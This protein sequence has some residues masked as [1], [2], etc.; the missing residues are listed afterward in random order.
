MNEPRGFNTLFNSS[1]PFKDVKN[2]TFPSE[3]EESC[4]RDFYNKEIVKNP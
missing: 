2:P 4:V 1:P 3:E